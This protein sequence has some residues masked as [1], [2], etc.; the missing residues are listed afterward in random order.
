MVFAGLWSKSKASKEGEGSKVAKGWRRWLQR[1]RMGGDA[2]SK[3][4]RGFTRRDAL[5]PWLRVLGPYLVLLGRLVGREHSVGAVRLG[6]VALR[7]DRLLVLCAEELQSLAVLLAPTRGMQTQLPGDAGDI[8]QLS[9]GAEI[10]VQRRFPALRT[11]EISLQ[12]FPAAGDALPAEVVAAGDGDGIL[13]VTQ[14]DGAGGFALQAV[15]GALRGHGLPAGLRSA[16]GI[17]DLSSLSPR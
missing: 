10:F 1:G 13:E 8:C 15:Q 7:A 2:P 16:E 12:P 9:A 4:L 17:E 5:R 14:A 11:G 6:R 3:G